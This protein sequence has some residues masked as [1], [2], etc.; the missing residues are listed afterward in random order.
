MIPQPRLVIIVTSDLSLVFFRGQIVHLRQAGFEVTCICSPG[1]AQQIARDQGAAVISLPMK[2]NIAPLKDLRA[3]VRLTFLLRRLRPNIVD[4]GTPKAGLLGLSAAALA[5]VPHRIYTLHGLRL[6]TTRGLLRGVLTLMERLS[7]SLAHRI[8][9]V[10]P[11]LRERVLELNLTTP[12][13]IYVLGSGSASGVDLET[14]SRTTARM[15]ECAR[16]RAVL[17]IPANAMVLGFVG[18]ITRDKGIHE[19]LAAYTQLR[20]RWPA[21]RLLL[22]GEFEVSSAADSDVRCRILDDPQIHQIPSVA[23]LASWYVLM[24]VL[25]FPTHREGLGNVSIEAQAMGVPVITTDATGARDSV[26]HAVTGLIVPVADAAALQGATATLLGD[27]VMRSKMSEAGRRWVSETFAAPAVWQLISKSY[28]AM[29][30]RPL[31]TFYQRR[32]KRLLDVL[33]A[34]TAL[35]L[36]APVLVVLGLAVRLALGSPVLFRQRRP[37]LRGEPFTM[38]KFRTMNGRCGAEG[39]LL[40]DGERLTQFG[41]FLRSTS[42]DELPELLNVLRGEMSLVGPRP[43]LMEYLPLYSAQQQQRHD[44]VPGITGWAQVNGRNAISWQRKFTLDTDYAKNPS[45][46]WDLRILVLT[47]TRILKRTAVTSAGHDTAQK[48]RGTQHG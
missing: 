25:L 7:C 8:R 1:P 38:V 26:L 33:L 10:S 36:F 23:D 37:G 46:E 16:L 15:V 27:P 21:L 40:P 44:V 32:G 24:D 9:A 5:R 30:A 4:A 17:K 11:S 20:F 45:F 31:P 41:R 35:I 34:A 3:L 13:R 6:E 29:L 12:Q 18:R 22:I 19:L 14:Y 2:R 39:R 28:R 42:L 48:F 47:V 43:L